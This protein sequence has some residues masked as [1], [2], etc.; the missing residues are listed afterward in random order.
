M[1]VM[2]MYPQFK[3][4]ILVYLPK[5]FQGLVAAVGDYYTWQLAE[6]VYGQG[7][8]AAFTTVCFSAFLGI[9]VT[10]P[11]LTS[12]VGT[13]HRL[14]PMAVVLLNQ[15][16]LQFSGDSLDHRCPLLLAL[17]PIW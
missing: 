11:R 15:D 17:G 10:R 7:S 8:N 6:K 5:V 1:G 2:S 16:T 13:H 4:I 12:Y 14:E 9:Y 3:A